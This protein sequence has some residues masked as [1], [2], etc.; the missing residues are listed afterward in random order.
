MRLRECY[1]KRRASA[2]TTFESAHFV[3]PNRVQGTLVDVSDNDFES[4]AG[5]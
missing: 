1:R 4:G 3:H 2:A 5:G